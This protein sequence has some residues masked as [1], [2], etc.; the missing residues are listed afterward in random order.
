M[1]IMKR[2]KYDAHEI[3]KVSVSVSVWQP[4][5]HMILIMNKYN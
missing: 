3:K 4:W 5:I 2:E 1:N